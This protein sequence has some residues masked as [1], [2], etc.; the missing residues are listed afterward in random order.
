MKKI[1]L[2]IVA[3]ML[4]VAST[5]AQQ[6]ELVTD[7]EWHKT[8]KFYYLTPTET[9]LKQGNYIEGNGSIT[10]HYTQDYETSLCAIVLNTE[11]ISE[12]KI[13]STITGARIIEDKITGDFMI[14]DKD[15][16]IIL[17]Y[18]GHKKSIVFK[19]IYTLP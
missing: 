11:P 6:R 10:I 2:L 19:D 7:T 1:F 13:V 12:T 4:A 14:L 18:S 15:D 5:N 17:L 3:I 16:D 9:D 8:A